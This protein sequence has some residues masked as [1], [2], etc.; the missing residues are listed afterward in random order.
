VSGPPADVAH[1]HFIVQVGGAEDES[2]RFQNKEI[3]AVFRS[4]EIANPSIEGDENAL[5]FHC[6]AQKIG[7]RYLLV[8]EQPARK[9]FR[10]HGPFFGDWPVAIAGVGGKV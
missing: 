6:E 7:V 5:F 3:S 4:G 10:E 2:L 1:G 9:G 8:S